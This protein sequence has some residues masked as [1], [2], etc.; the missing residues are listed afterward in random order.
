MGDILKHIKPLDQVPDIGQCPL[1]GR[2]E[3][4]RHYV[5]CCPCASKTRTHITRILRE[6][7]ESHE[8]PQDELSRILGPRTEDGGPLPHD[9]RGLILHAH[10]VYAFQSVRNEVSFR[11][12][13]AIG[14]LEEGENWAE[15]GVYNQGWCAREVLRAFLRSV[16][17]HISGEVIKDRADHRSCAAMWLK[18]GVVEWSKEKARL[19]FGKPL[20]WDVLEREG[21][22]SKGWWNDKSGAEEGMVRATTGR[23]GRNAMRGM[24]R[25]EEIT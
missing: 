12:Q 9:H 17:Y 10:L 3:T 24:T 14:N 13:K 11:R 22:A 6:Y 20:S 18:E 21:T 2:R 1:C 16:R 15:K 8:G 5:G 23:R 19:H 4:Q 7:G 25:Q